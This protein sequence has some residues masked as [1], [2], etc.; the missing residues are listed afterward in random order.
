MSGL[1][2]HG[3]CGCGLCI[4]DSVSGKL[5]GLW[6]GWQH[7]R[8]GDQRATTTAAQ[9][10]AAARHRLASHHALFRVSRCYG[11]KYFDDGTTNR[12][13]SL[14]ADG[15]TWTQLVSLAEPITSAQSDRDITHA[16]TGYRRPPVQIMTGHDSSELEAILMMKPSPIN[17]VTTL[18]AAI[19]TT[20]ATS[21]TV[22]D[23]TTFPATGNFRIKIDAEILL[24]TG[25][26]GTPSPSRAGPKAPRRQRTP[27]VPTLS[28]CLQ[29]V[30]WRHG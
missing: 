27:V 24:V 1:T 18:S 17:A 25:V 11:S 12:I 15:Y 8:H 28:I 9:R 22:T 3:A 20:T 10:Q 6:P 13:I 26:A 19:T 29:R 23:A 16:I 14:S 30:A 2:V 21:C 4:R 7:Q 5:N